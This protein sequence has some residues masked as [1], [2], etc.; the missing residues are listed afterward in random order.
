[1]SAS[2]RLVRHAVTDWTGIRWCGRTDLSLNEV[3]QAGARELAASL[4]VELDRPT[5]VTSPALR[6]RET[7]AI[8][9]A[10]FRAG[11]TVDRDLR[12]VDFGFVEGLTW[13]ET[14]AGHPD[15]AAAILAGATEV[16]WPGGERAAELS[17]RAA[18]LWLRLAARE[19]P[20]DTVVV[21]HGGVI[22]ALAL[23]ATGAPQASGT[24]PAGIVRLVEVAGQW[25]LM[26]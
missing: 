26:P 2:I 22:A 16:D 20:G 23:A 8:L 4:A 1:M 24:R 9:A 17:G 5:F 18:R 12:E 11:V 10:P 14:A 21:T 25:R 15:L 13:D 3:G 19:T 6:A 7:A